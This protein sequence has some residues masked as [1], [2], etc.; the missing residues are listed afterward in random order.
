MC[1]GDRGGRFSVPGAVF[2]HGQVFFCLLTCGE[3][4]TQHE[5]ASIARLTLPQ[6]LGL[7]WWAGLDVGRQ[8]CVH[9][10][11]SGVLWGSSLQG[12]GM[13]LKTC[14]NNKYVRITPGELR[15]S[16]TGAVLD[17]GSGAASAR[18]VKCVT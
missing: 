12:D 13:T 18:W 10:G 6:F 16:L 5:P 9:A 15:G 4:T 11:A 14:N 7:F 17:R 2:Y 8:V 3:S 1:T